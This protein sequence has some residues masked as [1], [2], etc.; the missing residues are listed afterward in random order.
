MFRC[1]QQHVAKPLAVASQVPADAPLEF[2]LK[3]LVVIRL[4]SGRRGENEENRRNGLKRKGTSQPVKA[5]LTER[6]GRPVPLHDNGGSRW[7]HL[8]F[9]FNRLELWSSGSSGPSA[10]DES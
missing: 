9:A 5:R 7:I 10:V 8:Q 3:E 1:G 6:T 2:Q 4:E